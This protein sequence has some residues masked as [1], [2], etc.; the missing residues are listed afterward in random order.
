MDDTLIISDLHAPYH[1]PDAIE[2]IKAAKDWYGLDKAKSAGDIVDNH[3]ASYHEIEYGTLSAR[4]E[5]KKACAT[6]Q[7]V[8]EVYPELTV[9]L[10]NHDV[11]NKRKA[12][13]AGIPEDML[14]SYNDI[15]GV[16]WEW[17]DK[18]YFKVNKYG[19][20][21][22]VHSMGSNTLSNA[23]RHS[24]HSIQGHHHGRYGIEYFADTEVLRW[25]MSVGCLINPD[26]PAF[27]YARG[28][29]LNRPIIGMGAI[30]EDQP[31][32]IPMQLKKSGRWDNTI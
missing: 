8:S 2:F 18:D 20:C 13:S 27:N 12:K 10:G 17:T 26:S 1:H 3:S 21:L 32:L 6:I 23:Q 28:A 25:S 22:L 5:H 14:A 19:S 24:H 11:L 9:V 31:H 29:T 30:I 15:Y 16:N 7:A 4:D